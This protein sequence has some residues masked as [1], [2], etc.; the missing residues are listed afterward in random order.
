MT[1]STARSLCKVKIWIVAQDENILAH[2]WQEEHSRP[3]AKILGAFA[4]IVTSKSTGAHSAKKYW[5][6]SKSHKYVEQGRLATKRTKKLLI[7]SMVHNY[8]Q[9]LLRTDVVDM[10][11]DDGDLKSITT[12]VPRPSWLNHWCQKRSLWHGKMDV[13]NISS[14]I[15]V[16]TVHCQTICQVLWT[17]MERHEQ[18]W[19]GCQMLIVWFCAN[20]SHKIIGDHCGVF[21]WL[22]W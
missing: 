14:T 6:P 11:W 3:G 10:L 8:K 12:L 5:N 4:C 17:Y 20:W 13:R 19:W 15:R 16:W 2:I 22:K 9:N 21:G 7:T 18:E 1:F